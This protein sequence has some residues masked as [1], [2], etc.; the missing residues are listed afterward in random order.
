MN[1]LDYFIFLMVPFFHFENEKKALFEKKAPLEQ[2]FLK[3][4]KTFF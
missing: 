2:L 4:L 1:A 3:K